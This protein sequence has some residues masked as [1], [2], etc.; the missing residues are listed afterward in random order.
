MYL[1]SQTIV[2]LSLFVETTPFN[3]SHRAA[4][5]PTGKYMDKSVPMAVN[6]GMAPLEVGTVDGNYIIQ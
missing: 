4:M 3:E 5:I 2:D 1:R 6:I